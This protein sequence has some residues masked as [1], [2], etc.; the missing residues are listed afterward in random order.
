MSRVNASRSSSRTAASQ[1][2]DRVKRAQRKADQEHGD[3]EQERAELRKCDT[4]DLLTCRSPRQGCLLPSV[5]RDRCQTREKQKCDERRHAPHLD[6]D[7]CGQRQPKIGGRG[8]HIG[9][10][11]PAK[12]KIEDA[13][14]AAE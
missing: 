11:E 2:Q 10:A 14:R 3:G 4:P 12:R 13:R 5:V 8:R 7:H 6:R 1:D 9:P